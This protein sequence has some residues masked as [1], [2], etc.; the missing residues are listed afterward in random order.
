MNPI[1]MIQQMFSKGNNPQ[2]I[3]QNMM[4]LIGKN[5][6]MLENLIGIAQAGNNGDVEAFARN[7]FKERGRDFDKEFSEFMNNFQS[8][9]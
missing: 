2:Q 8:G 1:Q 3:V 4:N 5:N 7:M 9:N 6:P